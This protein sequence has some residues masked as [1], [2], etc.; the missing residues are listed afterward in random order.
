VTAALVAL[1]VTTAGC[2]GLSGGDGTTVSDDGTEQAT[3]VPGTQESTATDVPTETDTET[4][5]SSGETTTERQTETPGPDIDLGS[6]EWSEGERYDY[7]IT[8]PNFTRQLGWEVTAVQGSNVTIEV[9][10]EVN[11]QPFNSTLEG[12]QGEMFE[13][14]RQHSVSAFYGTLRAAKLVGDGRSLTTGNSWTVTQ[15]DLEFDTSGQD[16]ETATVEVTGTGSYEGIECS[17]IEV[18]PDSDEVSPF[19]ACLDQDRPFALSFTTQTQDGNELTAELAGA[20]P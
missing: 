20:D 15:S 9:T 10:N 6:Y 16:W 19:T 13:L 3:T 4:P 7:N 18:T 17:V 2:G 12:T 8:I 14:A 1:L 5:D 11:G